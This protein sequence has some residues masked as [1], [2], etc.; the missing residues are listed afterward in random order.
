MPQDQKITICEGVYKKLKDMGD[1]THAEVIYAEI[2]SSGGSSADREI[3]ITNYL[4]KASFSGASVGDTITLIQVIDVSASTPS[5]ISSIWRNQNTGLDILAAPSINNLEVA[6][7]EAITYGQLVSA[8]LALGVQL[9]AVLGGNQ[10]RAQSLGVGL[11]TED[12]AL[13]AGLKSSI[14]ALLPV[15]KQV[16]APAGFKSAPDGSLISA[17]RLVDGVLKISDYTVTVDGLGNTTYTPG[18]YL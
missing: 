14:D 3:V 8:G 16:A 12:I 9:P 7:T 10:S 4:C 13:L 6:G 11:S 18:E 5:T 15:M 2:S 1:G 17:N